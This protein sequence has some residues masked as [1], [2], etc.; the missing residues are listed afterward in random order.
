MFKLA[1]FACVIALATAGKP[2][3]SLDMDESMVL[4]KAA[5]TRP[6][7]ESFAGAK[8][9]KKYNMMCGAN[10][11][12]KCKLP[13]AKAFDHHEGTLTSSI[14]RV[15]KLINSVDIPK[16]RWGV[17]ACNKIDRKKRSTYEIT[18][19]VRDT[20]GNDADQA[21]VH[22]ILFDYKAPKITQCITEGSFLEATTE[23]F[24]CGG[25]TAKDN[26]DMYKPKST[27]RYSIFKGTSCK[28][29]KCT[30]AQAMKKTN[31]DITFGTGKYSV[32]TYAHDFA[33][34]Y[35]KAAKDNK[36]EIKTKFTVRDTTP[37]QDHHQGLHPRQARV[38]H[39]L[40]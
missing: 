17:V 23:G 38:R 19:D 15:C 6:H 29:N 33:G 4:S 3:I 9:E 5:V 12:D 22:L 36:S 16:S 35:G 27:L 2:V 21:Y 34:T 1:L 28:C 37:P 20:S 32:Y 24:F 7:P 40:H 31:K 13:T 8:S 11:G 26:V 18:Y 14:R 39:F 10:S 25:T 30:I